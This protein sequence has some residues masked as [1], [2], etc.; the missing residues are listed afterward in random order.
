[1]IIPFEKIEHNFGGEDDFLNNIVITI[2]ESTLIGV[3][4]NRKVY[5]DP[6]DTKKCIKVDFSQDILDWKREKAYRHIR[7]RKKYQSSILTEYY[8]DVETNLGHGHV[9]ER[10]TDYDGTPSQGL[11]LILPNMQKSDTAEFKALLHELFCGMMIENIITTNM[12]Y[13]NFL[14][15]RVSASHST[16]R[17]VD[18]IG[19]HAKI[20]V[21]CYCNSLAK[22]HV[23]KYFIRFIDD[24]LKDFPHIMTCELANSFKNY[25]KMV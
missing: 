12:E 1:M 17:I 22:K 3:G 14:V 23:K 2:D 4:S 18:N 8:G 9:F 15:Q 20:P 21:V 24:M 13:S 19:T 6:C 7:Q 11:D 5:I 10:I 16:I 25:V